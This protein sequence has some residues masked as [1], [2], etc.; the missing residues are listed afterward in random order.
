[1]G[2][3]YT[4]SHLCHALIRRCGILTDLSESGKTA[5]EAN[6]IRCPPL[7]AAYTVYRSQ[8]PRPEMSQARKSLVDYVKI[9]SPQ[10]PEGW[11]ITFPNCQEELKQSLKPFL[12]KLELSDY[13]EVIPQWLSLSHKGPFDAGSHR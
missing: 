9:S 8:V 13:P 6:N 12:M 2:R 4:R 1:M 10:P 5:E 7:Y 3:Q 11:E